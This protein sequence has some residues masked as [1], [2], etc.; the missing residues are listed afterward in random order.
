MLKKAKKKHH[1]FGRMEFARADRFAVL[2]CEWIA[3]RNIRNV[4]SLF[5]L[6]NK[7]NLA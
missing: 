3:N 7:I 4:N 1:R 6:F 5:W 2:V